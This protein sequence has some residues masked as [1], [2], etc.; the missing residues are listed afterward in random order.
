MTTT[1]PRRK[2]G[3]TWT[4]G[5]WWQPATFE[6]GLPTAEFCCPA[7]CPCILSRHIHTIAPDGAVS[8]SLVCPACPV[9]FHEYVRLDGWPQ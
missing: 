3:Q 7:G 8:P 9:G 6:D 4:D 2:E 1:I 5:P